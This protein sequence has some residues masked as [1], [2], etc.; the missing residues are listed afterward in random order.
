ATEASAGWYWQFNRKQGYKHD[1]SART[2][3][4]TWNSSIS[5]NSNWL[6]I[7]DPCTLELGSAWRIPTLTEWTNADANGSWAN[8]TDAY[9]S[10]LKL[11]NSG[12][13]SPSDGTLDPRGNG[14]SNWSTMQG[15][16]TRAW[17][18]NFYTGFCGLTNLSKSYGFSVRCIKD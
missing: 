2:P 11:H 6:A 5:E 10:V 9:N 4:T 1:G 12:Y 13:L 15:D 7:N 3:N 8:P 17:D 14:G 18:L 16:D